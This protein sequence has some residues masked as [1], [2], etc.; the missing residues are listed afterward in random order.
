MVSSLRRRDLPVV[1]RIYNTT[2]TQL[3]GRRPHDADGFM[4]RFLHA[5]PPMS[6]S[7]RYSM[8]AITARERRRRRTRVIGFSLAWIPRSRSDRRVALIRAFAVEE[9]FQRLGV[10]LEILSVQREQLFR[11]GFV[12]IKMPGIQDK[13]TPAVRLLRRLGAEIR[14]ILTEW[15]KDLHD[16]IPDPTKPLQPEVLLTGVD[17]ID[18]D[19]L[20]R[21]FCEFFADTS[22]EMDL[23]SFRKAH[24]RNSASTLA[25]LQERVVGMVLAET[26]RG[27]GYI[28]HAAV[29]KEFRNKGI[30]T[31]LVAETL[32]RMK[33]MGLTTAGTSTTDDNKAMTQ[34]LENLGFR[35]TSSTYLMVVRRQ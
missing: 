30:G 4:N 32:R 8:K 16:R 6:F 15:Q 18:P 9:K 22:V 12:S 1:R 33:T 35:L 2:C 26:A 24:W 23:S 10:G 11:N 34:I 20:H 19:T 29:A 27:R 21:Y 13:N 3:P 25:K 7:F 14:G 5:T 17:D 28:S 31:H